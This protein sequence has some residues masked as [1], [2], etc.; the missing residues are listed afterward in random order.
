MVLYYTYFSSTY[1]MAMMVIFYH[2]NIVVII[3]VGSYATQ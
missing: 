2:R 3:Y 1:G